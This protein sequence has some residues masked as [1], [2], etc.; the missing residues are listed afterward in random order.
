MRLAIRRRLDAAHGA[1]AFCQAHP[2]PN[3]VAA[4]SVRRLADILDTVADWLQTQWRCGEEI[5]AARA[6]QDA[7]HLGL[8]SR[9]AA[10]V[11]FTAVVAAREGEAALALRIPRDTRVGRVDLLAEVKRAIVHIRRH[12][13]VF[14]HYGL[15]DG[16]L[17]EFEGDL[18]RHELVERRR[19]TNEAAV[20]EAAQALTE[21]SHEAQQIVRHLGALNRLRFASAPTSLAAWQAASGPHRPDPVPVPAETG[22]RI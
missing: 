2:D 15:P 7:T 12:E 8:R 18:R 11:K 20:A 10:L 17:G 21:L 3:P 9:L 16:L 5:A 13:T 4:A 22:A 1:L 14:G 19:A 6:A